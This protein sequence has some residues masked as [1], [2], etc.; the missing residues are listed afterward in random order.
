MPTAQPPH[1]LMPFKHAPELCVH[2]LRDV[3]AALDCDSDDD[4]SGKGRRVS[5]RPASSSSLMPVSSITR[6]TVLPS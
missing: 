6:S 4:H 1:E 5:R 2:G 3:S